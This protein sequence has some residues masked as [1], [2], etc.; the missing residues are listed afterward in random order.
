MKKVYIQTKSRD[1][2]Y[3]YVIL[4]YYI[5]CFCLNVCILCA[6]EDNVNGKLFLLLYVPLQQELF[7]TD[8]TGMGQLRKPPGV[9]LIPAVD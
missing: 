5:L 1:Q 4:V 2:I 7:G 9:E 8:R 6:A 3:V